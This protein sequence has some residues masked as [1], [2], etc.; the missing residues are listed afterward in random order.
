M[1]VLLER[2]AA[3]VDK[4]PPMRPWLL[5]LLESFIRDGDEALFTPP[6]MQPQSKRET[7]PRVF[8]SAESLRIE[9]DRLVARRAPLLAPL[10]PEMA[11]AGGAGIGRK[12]GDRIIKRE[13]GRLRRYVELT[14]RIDAL[15]D[16]ILRA[17][18]RERK[19]S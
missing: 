7:K 6:A 9:R 17:E 13:D 14:R 10:L 15:N 2:Q 5:P 19:A 11:A 3:F 12:R 18:H 8:R 4:H 16:R 1:A